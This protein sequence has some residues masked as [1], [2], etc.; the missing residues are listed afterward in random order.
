MDNKRI[1]AQSPVGAGDFSFLKRSQT[2]FE[3]H[4]SSYP[5]RSGNK[6]A[7]IS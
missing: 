4:P 1:I 3:V 2:F 5:A 7:L 6:W